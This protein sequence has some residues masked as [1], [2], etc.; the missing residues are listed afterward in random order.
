MNRPSDRS[1]LSIGLLSTYPPTQCGLATFNAAL[2]QHLARQP[3]GASVVRVVE[4]PETHPGSEVVAHLVNGSAAS[5]R[6]AV[7]ALNEHDVVLVQHEYGIFGGPDGRDVVELLEA[8]TVPTIVVLHTVLQQPT[9]QQ[10]WV[11]ERL[12]SR[13]DLLV[14]MTET[15][16]QRLLALY[17]VD[18]SRTVVVPH[19]AVGP[20]PLALRRRAPQRP[21]ILT[22]GLIG[23]GKGIEWVIDALPGLRDLSPRY[24]VLGKT[25]PKVLEHSGEAYR[26]SLVRRAARHGVLDLLD[27]DDRYLTTGELAGQI[28]GAAVVLL[29]YDSV[30]QV[31]SGVL[32]EAVAAGRPVVSTAFPHARELLA[33]GLGLVV[34]QGDSAAIEAAL[35]RVLTEPGLATGMAARAVRKAPELLWDAVAMQYR[36]LAEQ[37]VAAELANAS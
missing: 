10:R 25:H 36:T 24:V 19:G 20:G 14:T 7:C 18:P 33:D 35:R 21:V 15:G 12:V 26:E 2:W 4:Q 6:A 17:D 31:T 1:G 27:L 23:P 16:R 34:P 9:P 30:E 13:A 11:L 22:W 3:G 8:L 5:A 37:L 29:P 32:V 28:D